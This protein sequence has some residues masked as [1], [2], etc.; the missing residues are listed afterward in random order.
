MTA[1]RQPHN[2]PV[3]AANAGVADPASQADR[4][5]AL[6]APVHERARM[7]ARRLCRS[8][9]EG[10]D[11][12]QDA[13]VRA[14]AKLP[15]LRDDKAFPAWFYRILLS[16]HKNRTRGHFWRRLLP[17]DSIAP[18]RAQPVGDDGSTW[19]DARHGERRMR[20]ALETLPRVQREAVV[21][22]DIDGYRLAEI[23]EMQGVSLSAV[24]SRLVRGRERL[25]KHYQ[26]RGY[27]TVHKSAGR[28]WTAQQ[29]M[30]EK[31]NAS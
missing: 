7:T 24:K 4:L 8:D 3:N 13:A 18:G 30:A 22:F 26:A 1:E 23:A 28:S 16:Q 31:R 6:L 9:A 14:L 19:E 25:R 2:P 20:T 29:N 21:L 12:F 17:L 27:G 11:L 10:D 15:A 5:L